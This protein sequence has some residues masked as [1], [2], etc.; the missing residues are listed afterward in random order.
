LALLILTE[1]IANNGVTLL[2]KAGMIVQQKPIALSWQQWL[3]NQPE[4]QQAEGLIIR[5]SRL[6]KA[7]L[8]HLPNLQVI[9][10]HGVGLDNLPLAEIKQRKIRLTFTPGINAQSVAEL[11]LALMLMS[12]HRLPENIAVQQRLTG[13]ML[14]G[15]TVGLIG[16]GKI[17][18]SV[19]K[20]L[21]P[22]TTNILVWN[23]RPKK[24][25]Y[26]KQ[27]SLEQLLQQADVVSLHLPALPETQCFLNQERLQQLS[28][29]AV[30]INTARGT[31]VDSDALYQQ[32]LQKRFAGAAVD[33]WTKKHQYSLADFQKLPNFIITPHIGA[34]TTETLAASAQRCAEEILR[35]FKQQPALQPYHFK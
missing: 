12:L 25:R 1:P 23:H 16:Y 6:T 32:L 33:V 13:S 31:L 30:L 24:I 18:Q 17:A 3:A 2:E 8:Q 14:S 27:V 29:S 10:R 9:A 26:G 19:E 15:K 4:L 11:T 20:L 22:F 21:Q 28:K 34:E 35:Y 7:D 5:A